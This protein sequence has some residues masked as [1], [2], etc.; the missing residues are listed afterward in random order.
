MRP[1]DTFLMYFEYPFVQRALLV[2]ILVSLC[3]SLLGVTLVLKHFSFI[4]DGLSHVAFGV[5]CVAVLLH[6]SNDMLLILPA[7][8]VCAVLMLR[9]GSR[10][11]INGDASL[12]MLS[13]SSLAI[14]YLLLNLFS[15]SANISGD[16]CTTLFGSTSILTLTQNQVWLSVLLSVS[17]LAVS[18]IFYHRIFAVTFDETFARTAG[19]RVNAYK[20]LLAA[21]IG[22][23]IVLAMKL[24]GSLLISALIVFPSLS[25]MHV[26]KNYRAVVIC[27]ACLS[28]LCAGLGIVIAVIAGTPVG[29]TIV[30][31]QLFAFLFC[32]I[33]GGKKHA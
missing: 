27:S 23:V 13:V 33:L 12:A 25:S 16:I 30:A 11:K 1:I 8:I 17:V 7:T 2:G 5:M 26:F 29:S 32:C 15:A 20:L 3:A 6:L 9:S 19:L 24:V 10:F 18:I 4:G 21:L 31:V 14:G 22:V 28:V